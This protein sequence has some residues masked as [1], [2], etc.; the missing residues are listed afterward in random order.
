MRHFMMT[1]MSLAAFAAAVV[2]AQAEK[3]TA[4]PSQTKRAASKAAFNSYDVCAKKALDLGF[5]AGQAGRI[6]YMCQC[7][8]RS[9]SVCETQLPH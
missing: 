4:R 5:V 1:V 7:M 2:T 8:G 6:A 3:Q 9:A